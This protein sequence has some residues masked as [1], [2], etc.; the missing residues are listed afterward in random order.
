VIDGERYL[1]LREDDLLAIY[2]G[3]P[4]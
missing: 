4:A 1:M 2:E 3:Q